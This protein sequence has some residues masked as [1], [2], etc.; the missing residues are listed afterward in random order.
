MVVVVALAL[1]SSL[2]FGSHARAGVN[3]F[4]VTNFQADYYLNKSDPQGH[5]DISEAISVDFHDYNH[6]ILRA[7]PASYKKHSL[8]LK[9]ES[10][11]SPSGAP[12]MYSTYKSSGHLFLKIGDPNRRVTGPQGYVVKYSVDNVITYFTDHHE[13]YWDINGDQWN[14]PFSAVTA[15]FHIPPNLASQLQDRMQCYSGS[16][17]SREQ[18]CQMTVSA[19]ND[20]KILTFNA[21]NLVADENLSAVMAFQKGTFGPYTWRDYVGEHKGDIIISAVSLMAVAYVFRRW[22]RWGKDP[23]GSGIVV[24]QY[25]PPKGVSVLDAGILQDYRL[26][27]KDVT[28]IIIDLAIRGYVTIT[29]EDKKTLIFKTGT[30]TSLTLNKTDSKLADYELSLLQT[31]FDKELKNGN[32]VSLGKYISGMQAVIQKIGKDSLKRLTDAGFFDNAPNRPGNGLLVYALLVCIAM[33]TVGFWSHNWIGGLISMAAAVIVII[34]MILMPRRSKLGVMY[35]EELAGLKLYL[36]TAEADRIKMLQGPSAKYAP[37]AKE[38]KR[39]V[40]LFEKLMPFAV[41]FGVEKAWAGQFENI[42]NSPPEWYRG[43]WT[44][45]NAVMLANHISTTNAAF[46]SSF[47]PPS[48][49][50]SSGFSGGGAGGGG[51]GGGGGGW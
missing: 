50:S 48:S 22:W 32:T 10:V 9:V 46:N 31:L 12:A 18:N 33:T 51:G 28:A 40:Q 8:D 16:Y 17:G 6:G 11:T 38:P 42:Y 1:V 23:K 2:A 45:F 15:R 24:P 35:N 49:S 13:L 39:T 27:N 30:L 21:N 4:T 25:G 14:Q 20:G 34:I 29:E 19:D 37:N 5:M 47:S 44:T 43:N 3:D 7:I 36:N 41:I 26:D